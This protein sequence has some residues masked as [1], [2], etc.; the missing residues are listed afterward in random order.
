MKRI[1][2]MSFCSG[3]HKILSLKI[4]TSFPLHPAD[5]SS[6]SLRNVSII[7]YR[8]T[9]SQPRRPRFEVCNVDQAAF[10]GSGMPDSNVAGISC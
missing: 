10:Q 7:P 4:P 9:V 3:C 1:F 6:M 2:L 5:G 8:G